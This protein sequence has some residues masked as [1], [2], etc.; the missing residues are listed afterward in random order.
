MLSRTVGVHRRW[1]LL[2]RG[3]HLWQEY[4]HTE[5]PQKVQKM[6]LPM[7]SDQK[8]SIGGPCGSIDGL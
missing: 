1:D 8:L 6:L 3:R 2:K 7:S 5:D 4:R